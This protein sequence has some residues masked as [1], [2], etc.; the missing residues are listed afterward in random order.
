MA[1]TTTH[2]RPGSGRPRLILVQG[3]SV[4]VETPGDPVDQMEFE[5]HE[6]TVIGSSSDADLV[7]EGLEPVHAEVMHDETDEYVV[8]DRSRVSGI[9]VDGAPVQEK[10]L[11]TGDRLQLGDV[12]FSFFREEFAD[13]GRPHGGREGGEFSYQRDQPPRPSS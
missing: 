13:H 9:F 8:H 6:S 1:V 2:G 5:L 7:F 10:L 4:L 12:C 3:G 11:R